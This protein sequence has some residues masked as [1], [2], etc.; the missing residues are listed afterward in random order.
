VS[1]ALTAVKVVGV[2]LLLAATL[3]YIRRH[4]RGRLRVARKSQR[5]VSV[6]GQA[7][8]SKAASVAV[9]DIGGT[10]YAV[11]VTDQRVSLLLPDPVELPEIEPAAQPAPRASAAAAEAKPADSSQKRTAAGYIGR[12]ERNARGME[13]T[14]STENAEGTE[15]AGNTGNTN[16]R[17]PSF[18]EA[19]A[20]QFRVLTRRETAVPLGEL[21]LRPAGRY[22]AADDSA[23]FDAELA[24]EL[25]DVDADLNSVTMLIPAVTPAA[26]GSAADSAARTPGTIPG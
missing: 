13:R 14:E 10:A 24:A 23:D 18:G 20:Q 15:T 19:L 3:M 5:P 22:E 4:D 2:F 11:A 12:F 6:L 25:S 17:R 21:P 26:D 8:L 16:A 1:G 7:R 9:V